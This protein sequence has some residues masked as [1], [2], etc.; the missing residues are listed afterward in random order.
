VWL[1]AASVLL[2][3]ASAKAVAGGN[4][5]SVVC[6]DLTFV[7]KFDGG[8]DSVSVGDVLADAGTGLSVT[9]TQIKDPPTGEGLGASVLGDARCRR[10]G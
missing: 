2:I 3:G 10:K 1:T 9:V 4:P 5:P 6:G 8:F 7:F